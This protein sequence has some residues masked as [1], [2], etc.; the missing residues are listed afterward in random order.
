MCTFR[1]R[2]DTHYEKTFE[3][4]GPWTETIYGNP[5]VSSYIGMNWGWGASYN[6]TWYSASGSW[7][8]AGYDFDDERQMITSFNVTTP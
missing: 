4:I 2:N 8:I 1:E 3:Q 5:F 6:N 7:N